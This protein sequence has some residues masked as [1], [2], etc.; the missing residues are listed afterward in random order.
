MYS[1]VSE[2]IADPT[3]VSELRTEH[4]MTLVLALSKLKAENDHLRATVARLFPHSLV[5]AI[6]FVLE[7]GEANG[8]DIAQW[9]GPPALYLRRLGVLQ[10][11]QDGVVR[12][13][14]DGDWVLRHEDGS[15][16]TMTH[17]EF[18]NCSREL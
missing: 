9:L 8:E 13:V 1:E 18:L 14:R 3:R 16:Q 5:G 11:E 10:V 15:V 17:E 12:H 4:V 7:G 6:R 2:I